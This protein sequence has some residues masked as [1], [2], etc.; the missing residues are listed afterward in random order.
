MYDP[1]DARKAPTTWREY[2]EQSKEMVGA[3][4]WAWREFKTPLSLR[5]APLRMTL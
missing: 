3:I 4:Q 5:F 2:L 1:E